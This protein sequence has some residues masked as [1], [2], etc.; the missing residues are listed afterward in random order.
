MATKALSW[1]PTPTKNAVPLKRSQALPA[2]CF[3]KNVWRFHLAKNA[4]VDKAPQTYSA[5]QYDT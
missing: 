4:L 3:Q 5:D 1:I 2:G